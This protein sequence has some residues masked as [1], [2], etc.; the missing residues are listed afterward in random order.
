MRLVAGLLLTLILAFASLYEEVLREQ[1]KELPLES[2]IVVGEG[3]RELIVFMNPDCPHCR[4][5]WSVLKRHLK[6]LKVYVFIVPFSHWGEENLKKSLYIVC[7]KEPIR[8]LDEVMSGKLDR[9]EINPPRCERINEHLRA[10]QIIGL[11]AVPLNILPREGKILEG[12][13]PRLYEYLEI[14]S[15]ERL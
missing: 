12:E 15:N 2:A 7:S 3:E 9:K 8:A 14:K 4:K 5:E 1:I 6:D 10:A 11:R 13:S